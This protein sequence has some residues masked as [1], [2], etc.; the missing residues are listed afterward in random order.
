[1]ARDWRLEPGDTWPYQD[2]PRVSRGGMGEVC[3]N[4]RTSNSVAGWRSNWRQRFDDLTIGRGSRRG[5]AGAAVN[6]N[7][8]LIFETHEIAR[9]PVIAME[10]LRWN[11]EGPS[12]WGRPLAP[13]AVDAIL[14]V[15]KVSTPRAAGILHRDIK[16]QLPRRSRRRDQ[17][18][19]LRPV[20]LHRLS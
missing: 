9:I 5:S 16:P 12:E 15:S 2:R 13:E 19:R 20:D 17:D 14:Q 3:E 11:T 10:L 18:R 7:C 4:R 1:M 6:R 8:V